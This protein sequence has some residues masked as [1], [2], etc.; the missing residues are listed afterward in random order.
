MYLLNPVL[1]TEN[2]NS[3]NRKNPFF[4]RIIERFS[5]NKKGSTK[6]TFHLSLTSAGSAIQYQPGDCVGVLPSND[7]AEVNEIL[8]ALQHKGSE[9][10]VDPENNAPISLSAYLTRA[11]NLQ[12]THPSLLKMAQEHSSTQIVPDPEAPMRPVELFAKMSRIAIPLS[13]I[14]RLFLPQLP[15]F[16]SIASA[17]VQYPEEI[18]LTVALASF[19]SRGRKRYGVASRFLCLDAIVNETPIP[20]YLQPSRSFILP[21]DSNASIIL[22][23]CG[24]G[25]APLRAFLQHRVSTHAKG[26][27][28]LF[29]GER[30]RSSDYYYEDFFEALRQ[31]KTLRLDLAFSRDSAE[32]I[33]VQHRMWEQ[34]RDLWAWLQE[35]AYLYV[36]GDAQN[37]AIDVDST[38][39]RIAIDQGSMTDDEAR[40]YLKKLRADK[41]YLLDVY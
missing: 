9:F 31:Q 30:H 32:K 28:W 20:I 4:S 8:Q 6:K 35:G 13:D 14:P 39:I 7:P 16:Y 19:E 10:V 36:C 24:T 38:L 29:F 37:M 27:N 2:M 23:G 26:R 41:R 21:A 5:L 22:V 17:Q 1:S 15:R 25:I 33:Y 18:H 40:R 34:R 11:S 3:T 12:K